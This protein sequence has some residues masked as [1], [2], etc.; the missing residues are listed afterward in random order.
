M[1]KVLANPRL[2]YMAGDWHFSMMSQPVITQKLEAIPTP[3]IAMK[4]R[5]SRT[6]RFPDRGRGRAAVRFPAAECLPWDGSTG[7]CSSSALASNS[8]AMPGR[9]VAY[10]WVSAT[11][12]PAP[13]DRDK[14]F[15]RHGLN[16]T[17][18]DH[19]QTGTGAKL[20]IWQL[21]WLIEPAGKLQERASCS[22]RTAPIIRCTE[23]TPRALRHQC[24]SDGLA[25]T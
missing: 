9:P 11:V 25:L 22:A 13:R 2:N 12:R 15:F 23:G 7:I 1:L 18:P 3:R 4:S 14:S 16:S 10:A 19:P 17:S 21:A 24:N 6:Q 20:N 5:P 8:L